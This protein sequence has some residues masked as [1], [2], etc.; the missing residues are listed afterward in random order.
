MRVHLGGDRLRDVTGVEHVGTIVGHLPQHRGERRVAENRAG[1]SR[2]AVGRVEVRAGVGVG[3]EEFLVGEKSGQPRADGKPLVRESD[4]W[5]E[6]PRPRQR[7]V[8]RMSVREQADHAGGTDRTPPDDGLRRGHGYAITQEQRVGRR[9]GGGLAPVQG[10]ELTPIPVQQERTAADATR[11]RLHQREHHLDG[12]GR[13]D[14]AA[15]SLEHLGAGVGGERI[16]GGDHPVR[17]GPAWL[18]GPAARPLG[19]PHG[20][21]RLHQC[22]VRRGTGGEHQQPAQG[23]AAKQSHHARSISQGPRR[24]AARVDL[25]CPPEP[26]RRWKVDAYETPVLRSAF[27]VLRSA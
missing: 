15:A 19:R 26:W 12:D 9:R 14:R 13:I 11:L 25:T 20:G 24:G 22:P 2:L 17:R 16:G 3:G 1:R 4:G 23:C 10:G 6:E 18:V 21:L 8:E 27:C 5:R 7:A